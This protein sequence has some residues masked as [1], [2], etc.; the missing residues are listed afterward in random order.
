LQRFAIIIC[1]L[2][3][4]V[5]TSNAFAT[6]AKMQRNKNNDC[7]IA[8]DA[9]S[10]RSYNVG[11]GKH[12]PLHSDD[13]H[14][15]TT[16]IEPHIS[17]PT[18]LTKQRIPLPKQQVVVE[19]TR[20]LLKGVFWIVS[21]SSQH[22]DIPSVAVDRRELDTNIFR[23][24]PSLVEHVLVSNQQQIADAYHVKRFAQQPSHLSHTRRNETV[25]VFG[26]YRNRKKARD[27][28]IHRKKFPTN[29]DRKPSPNK[30]VNRAW[31]FHIIVFSFIA[32]CDDSGSVNDLKFGENGEAII[33]LCVSWMELLNQDSRQKLCD[34]F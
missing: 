32:N 30:G 13:N 7:Q 6:L 4:L 17:C 22:S 11:I 5:S 20:H 2:L 26:L 27:T 25:W 18:T 12:Q 29:S 33:A 10:N 9:F 31:I 8:R 23:V 15:S 21:S 34:V 1:S 28:T 24:E 14:R 3:V 19:S 16:S